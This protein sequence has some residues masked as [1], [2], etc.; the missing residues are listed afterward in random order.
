MV[1]VEITIGAG[2]TADKLT[3]TVQFVESAR[4]AAVDGLSA[5]GDPKI[6]LP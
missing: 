4:A 1:N 6:T 5:T 3:G 2:A